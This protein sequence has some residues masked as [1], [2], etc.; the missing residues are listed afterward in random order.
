[1]GVG[2]PDEGGYRVPL[3]RLARGAGHAVAF[4]GSQASGPAMVDGAAFPRQHEGYR[5]YA[6]D[7]GGGRQGIAPLVEQKLAA[8][9]PHIVVLLI[10]TND[11]GASV[12]DEAHAPDRLAALI[13]RVVAAAP[14]ALLVVVR[15]IPS[16]EDAANKRIEAFDEAIPALVAARAQAGRHVVAVDAYHAFTAHPD[17]KKGLMFNQFHPNQAGY[18]LLAEVIYAGVKDQLP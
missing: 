10:G 12:I 18:A 17:F 16:M 5:G 11:V 14:Q 1:V 8:H 3:F 7:T 9:Q 4:V 2:S 6:I 15:I 13:D